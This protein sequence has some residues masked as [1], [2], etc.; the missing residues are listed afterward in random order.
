MRDRARAVAPAAVGAWWAYV[1]VD[2]LTHAV[3]L[4]RWWR[5]TGAFWLAPHELARRIPIAYAG[6]AIYCLGLV[7]LLVLLRGERPSVGTALRLGAIVGI[8]YGVASALCIYSAVDLPA[9]FLLV[10]PAAVTVA[11]ATAGAAGAWVLGG[12]GRWRRVGAALGLGL[13][14]LIAAILAQNVLHS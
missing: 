6:F 10:G 9:S 8:A 13:L 4:A 7:A 5:A 12:V 3:V 1:V 14:A 11:S 2:F